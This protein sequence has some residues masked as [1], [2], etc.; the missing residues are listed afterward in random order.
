MIARSRPTVWMA[1]LV[2]AVLVWAACA[3]TSQRSATPSASARSSRQPVIGLDWGTAADVARPADAFPVQASPTTGPAGPNT[4]GHPGHFPGQAVMSDVALRDGRFVAVGY[5]GPSPWR[6]IAWTSDDAQHWDLVEISIA[7]S[8]ENTFAVS[9]AATT[10][11]FVAVGRAGQ[12]PAAWTSSNGTA[13]TRR[14]VPVLGRTSDWERMTV[15]E[16][17]PDGLIAGGSVGPE[18][19]DR[20]ARFWRSGDGARWTTVPDDGAFAG[21]EVT[22]LE[23]ITHGW[24]ALGRIGTGQRTTG[25]TTWRSTD[26][27]RWA[28]DD[29][30]SIAVG[31]ARA[32]TRAPDGAL[33]AVGSEPDE[34]AAYAWR[35]TDEGSTWQQAPDAPA[36]THFGRKVRMT[37]V[38]AMP[39]GVLA[40]GNL[41]EVQ[42]GTGMSWRSTDGLTWEPSPVQAPFGQAEPLAVVAGGP[43]YVAVGDFGA[44]DDYIPRVWITPPG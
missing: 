31:Y 41:V 13:W 10:N 37:D 7:A 35:S 5:V 11:G 3:P 28:R 19:L 23:Q 34:L 15:V 27:V 43:G 36:L 38:V 42:Y 32:V 21:S 20:R 8:D 25:S 9:V 40:V 1:S 22:A 33:V 29:D 44:P 17:G 18:L 30:A 12:R 16:A 6:P 4:A 39:D 2:S 24:L 14:E 26:G